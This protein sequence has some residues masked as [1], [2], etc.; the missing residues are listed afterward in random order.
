L[1]TEHFQISVIHQKRIAETNHTTE[2][3][4]TASLRIMK[5]SDKAIVPTNR[6]RFAGGNDIYG[7]TDPLVPAKGQTRVETGIAIGVPKGTYGRL[8]ARS[9]RA[10]K[11]GIAVGGGVI[12]ADYTGKVKAI[13][14]THGEVE[15]LFKAGDRIAQLIIARIANAEAIEVEHLGAT[16]RGPLGFRSRDLNPKGSIM[17]TEEGVKICFLDADTSENKFFGPADIRYHPRL[18]KEKEMLSSAHINAALRRMMNDSF[19]DKI[20]VAGKED[21]RGQERGHELVRLRER[22]KKMRDEWIEK[23]RLLFNK[24]R[25]YIAKDESLPT[26]IGQGC[27]DALVEGHLGQETTIEI[28]T[29]DLYRKGLSDWIRDYLLSYD[30]CQHSKSPRDAK[31]GL[32]QPLEVPYAA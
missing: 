28:V 9:G 21:E 17:A 2:K 30:E 24:N 1:N 25:L 8:A 3:R 19:L 31:Y 18:M 16:E 7:L 32:L 6:S 22:G 23:D 5:L 10:S 11:M 12:D 4:G 26:E 29:R 14:R 27:H 20:R 13:L 15:C